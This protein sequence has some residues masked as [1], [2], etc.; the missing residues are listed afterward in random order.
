M[1]TV[2]APAAL[3]ELP[4][5]LAREGCSRNWYA[6]LTAPRHEKS[7]V[8]HLDLRG[9]ESY[10]P[11]YESKRVW[12]NRQ[13]MTLRLPLFPSYL[14]VHIENRERRKVLES[15]GVR[16]ILGN[17]REPIPLPDETIE[18]LRSEGSAKSLEPYSDLVIGQTVRIR[19][20]AFRG[21]EGTLVRKNNRDRFVMTIKL[22]NRHVAA[23]L[24]ANDLELVSEGA[25]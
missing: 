22:I 24:D 5:S 17:H 1:S 9:I 14:F 10:M 11:T 20:G 25:Q 3:A 12:N 2:H 4:P 8:R 6:V 18:F 21:L 7:A 13:R 19:S 16:Q 15:P 23:E